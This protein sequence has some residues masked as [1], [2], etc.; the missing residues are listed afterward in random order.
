MSAPADTAPAAASFPYEGPEQ[1]REPL[2]A[3]LSRVVDPEIS[4]NIVDVGLVYGV[5]V[6]AAM[7]HVRITMTSAACP[8]IELLMDEAEAELDK[9]VPPELLIRVE[10]VWEP[11][12][13]PERMS[14]GA[15]RFMGW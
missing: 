2:T 4:M 15:K 13:S 12:W 10:L 7:A 3:A 11:P 14:A 1:L 8:V 5:T 9:V 6:D